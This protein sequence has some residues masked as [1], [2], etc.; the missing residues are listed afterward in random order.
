MGQSDSSFN[1]WS[2]TISGYITERQRQVESAYQPLLV[3][4]NSVCSEADNNSLD[5]KT[6]IFRVL[7]EILVQRLAEGHTIFAIKLNQQE[8]EPKKV[9]AGGVEAWYSQWQ[10]AL[11]TEL[12]EP[13]AKQVESEALVETHQTEASEANNTSMLTVISENHL[14]HLLRLLDN[15]VAFSAHLLKMDMPQHLTMWLKNRFDLALQ[16]KK[17]FLNQENSLSNFSLILQKNALINQTSQNTPIIYAVKKTADLKTEMIFW[18]QRIWR[19]ENHVMQQIH[20]IMSAD[21]EPLPLLANPLLNSEQQQAVEHASQQAFTII[22]GGPGTGKTFTVAQLVMALTKGQQENNLSLALAAPTGKAAQ[23]MQESLQAAIASSG[24][25]MQLP[26]AKTIHRLLGLGVDGQ[27]R[28]NE[29][30][31]LSEDIVIIDEAS[32]LGIELADA[33]LSAVKTGG[34]LILLGDANQL[35]AVDAGA[36]LAELCRLPQLSSV[37][38]QLNQSRRFDENSGVGKLATLIKRFM[39]ESSNLGSK[40]LASISLDFKDSQ[41]TLIERQYD[42]VLQLIQKDNHLFYYS[43][44]SLNTPNNSLS[45]FEM[46][47]IIKDKFEPYFAKTLQ[48]KNQLPKSED[49]LS[50]LKILFDSLNVFKVLTAGHHGRSG[51]ININT[52]LSNHHQ[53]FLKLPPSMMDWYHGRPIMILKNDYGLGLFNGDIGICLEDDHGKLQVYFENKTTP[54]APNMLTEANIATAYAMTIHKSQGSEFNEVAIVFDE[55]DERLLSQELIYT[56]VTRA[57]QTVSLFST[58]YAMKSAFSTPTHRNTGLAL[59]DA[60]V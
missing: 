1:T 52:A 45:N 19:A 57:K 43:L 16:L 25:Q 28:Y 13:I 38:Q 21:V 31:S 4:K 12:M 42:E 20:R 37:H 5:A 7:F 51:E 27:P 58:E 24:V 41:A 6:L 26:E 11:L 14:A 34:R 22:T 44:P 8:I 46:V 3:K 55:S 10:L 17:Y 2:A 47:N 50:I 48:F 39:D 59:H 23:R 32:M 49:R 53:R 56:A 15:P 30:N 18:I 60:C 29:K 40:G 35:A 33:L 36:V 54:I 9:M